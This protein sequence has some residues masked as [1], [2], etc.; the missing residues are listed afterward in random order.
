L[1]GGGV[2]GVAWETGVCAGL[3]EAGVD[4]REVDV[5]VGTSAGAIVG[6]QIASGF[7]PHLP[8]ERTVPPPPNGPA[9]DRQ[10][11]DL[12]LLGT[13]FRLWGTMEH[14]RPEIAAQIGKL[15]AS[16]PRDAQKGWNQRI[17][18]GMGITQ[19]P[20]L[21][22]LVNV[23]D[24]TTG[25]R[26]TIDKNDGI[27]VQAAV[28]A[29]SA[30]PGMFPPVELAG[31]LYMDGQV[32]SST[33]ADVLLP[34]APEQVWIVMPTN[35][36]TGQGIGPHAENMLETEV[37]AL[38]AAGSKVFVRMPQAA[39]SERLGKNLMDGKRAADAFTVGRDAGR[40]WAQELSSQSR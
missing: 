31:G 24:T 37:A 34:Y 23:V 29:S 25:E 2:V 7:L 38:R 26:R 27:D 8:R 20:Q 5:V 3:I 10:S 18:Y 36:V 13:I 28:A 17:A 1:G 39:D 14:T 12:M 30:V 22:L 33:N 16:M 40:V 9:V 6:A 19:W 32:H 21:P 4:P 35:R 15:T 11:L